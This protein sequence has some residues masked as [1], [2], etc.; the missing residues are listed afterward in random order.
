MINKLA[1]DLKAAMLARDK[2][3]V[4]V[5]KLIKSAIENKRIELGKDLDD[6]DLQAVLRSEAKKRNEAAEMYKTGGNQEMADKELAEL[7]IVEGYLPK[8]MSDDELMKLIE[9]V[10]ADLG[11]VHVG[12]IIQETIKRADGL[13]GGGRVSA[14]LMKK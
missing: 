7:K 14:I 4:S 8:Q 9:K 2:Q 13:A 11:D 12:Q 6:K 5:L 1:E 10:K 3:T